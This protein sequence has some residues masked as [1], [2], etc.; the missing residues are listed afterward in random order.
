[1]P[2][3][4]PLFVGVCACCP[5][6]VKPLVGAQSRSENLFY[7]TSANNINKHGAGEVILSID[8]QKLITD[9]LT[10]WTSDRLV[11]QLDS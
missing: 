11:L 7:Q 2:L 3:C 5:V 8:L 6:Q 4:L 9:Q 10:V 1:M